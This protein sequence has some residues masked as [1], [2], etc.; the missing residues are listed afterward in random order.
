MR[1]H[2]YRFPENISEEVRMAEGCGVILKSWEIIYP[3]SIPAEKR[4][5]VECVENILGGISVTHA[6]HLMKQ[7]GGAAWTEHC[8][9]SGGIFEVTPITLSGNN[10]K[11]RYN[12]HL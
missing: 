9:R 1:L 11:F 3:K 6:K 10:S 12:H 5:L 7:Y 8:D 4:E 2:Y